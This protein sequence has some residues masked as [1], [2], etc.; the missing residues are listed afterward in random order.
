M[1]EKRDCWASNLA[2]HWHSTRSSLPI[3]MGVPVGKALRMIDVNMIKIRN[4]KGILAREPIGVDNAA[5]ENHP[6]HERKQSVV[7]GTG[8]QY[9]KDPIST[10]QQPKN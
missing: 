8:D 5:R 4:N 3:D 1:L 9:R 7:A 10:L 6:L 2:N